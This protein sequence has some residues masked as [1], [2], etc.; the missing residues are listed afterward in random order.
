MPFLFQSEV[1]L[2]HSVNN[3]RHFSKFA[4][5]FVSPDSTSAACPVL[6]EHPPCWKPGVISAGSMLAKRFVSWEMSCREAKVW[7]RRFFVGVTSFA[8]ELTQL[9][10]FG[11]NSWRSK[12]LIYPQRSGGSST[13]QHLLSPT[14]MWPPAGQLL[15]RRG[16]FSAPPVLLTLCFLSCAF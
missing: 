2:C 14:G 5:A 4:S 9:L 15:S 16:I 13:S 6:E 8:F 7:R 1:F 10:A 11:V 12:F 3:E